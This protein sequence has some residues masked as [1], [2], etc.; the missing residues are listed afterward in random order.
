VNPLLAVVALAIIAGAVVAV[1]VRLARMVVL[2]VALV[3][4]AAPLLADPLTTPLALAARFIGA[5]LAAYLLA[6]AIRE[7]PAVGLLITPTEGSRIGWP[8]EVLVAAAAAL[9]GFAAH[10]LGAPAG[11]PMLAS[12]AGFAVAAV[13]LIPILTGR[14]VFRVGVGLLLLLAGGTLVR[15]GLDG[16]P[17]ELEQLLT[18]ALIVVVAGA[19]ASLALSARLDGPGGFAFA[20]EARP[21]TRRPSDAR[22]LDTR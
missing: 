6:I 14:D 5:I 18:S 7:R 1:S 15:A 21:R 11:G 22:P 19:V 8:T 12:A 20:A 9:V 4:A 16:T 13:S 10:G 3:L 2:G 17:G